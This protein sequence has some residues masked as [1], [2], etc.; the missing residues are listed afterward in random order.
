MIRSWQSSR[1]GRD[2]KTE[3]AQ[4]APDLEI[5]SRK[6]GLPLWHIRDIARLQI[7]FRFGWKSG[8]AMDITTWPS[9]MRWTAPTPSIDVP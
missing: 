7:D 2:D 8:Y 3:A 5:L 4:D 9:L 1:N 6:T